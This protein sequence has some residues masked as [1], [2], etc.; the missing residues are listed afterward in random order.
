MKELTCTNK[1]IIVEVTWD[2]HELCYRLPIELFLTRMR[3]GLD[4]EG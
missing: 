2:K 1:I 3:V 4:C